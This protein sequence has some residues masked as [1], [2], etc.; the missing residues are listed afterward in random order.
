MKKTVFIIC[1]AIAAFGAYSAQSMINPWIDCGADISCGAQKAGFNFPLKVKNY[2][3]RAMDGMFELRFP[4]EDGRQVI[5]RKAL[6]FN[7]K[8]DEND[9]IDISGDYNQYPTNITITLENGAKFNVR[10]EEDSYK[11]AN[12]AAESR[13]YSIICDKGLSKEDI[14]YFYNLL[15][16]AETLK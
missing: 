7:D 12:F 11:V 3:V 1:F 16:E 14:E 4:L 2:T 13:Y 6:N 15:A 8:A 5:V 9:I 10:G